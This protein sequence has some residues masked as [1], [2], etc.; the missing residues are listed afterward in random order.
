MSPASSATPRVSRLVLSKAA[1]RLV[2]LFIVLGAVV[3]LGSWTITASSLGNRIRTVRELDRHH[4]DLSRASNQFAV[5]S[6][7]CG[8]QGG[9]EC[10]RGALRD[11]STAVTHFRAELQA[12]ELPAN[13]LA[14]ADRLDG[15]ASAMI[16]SLDKLST[17]SDPSAYQVEALRFRTLADDFDRQ[18]SDLRNRVAGVG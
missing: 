16:R 1:K 17:I 15:T 2:V 9:I 7:S 18:W 14:L 10:L 8:V 13:A 6:Q 12:T 3:Q 11:M 5:R 4:D